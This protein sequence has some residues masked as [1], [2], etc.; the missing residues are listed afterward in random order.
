MKHLRTLLCLLA[1]VALFATACGDDDSSDTADGGDTG[2]DSGDTDT[3]DS[4]DDGDTGDDAGDAVAGECTADAVGGELTFGTYTPTSGLDPVQI[5]GAGTTSAIENL[6]I[7]DTLIRYDQASNEFVPHMAEALESNDDASEWTLTLRE[8]VTF[9][10][11][12]PL[13]AEAVKASIERHI[14]EDSTSR[15]RGL[16][17]G[18]VASMEVVDATTL[19]FTLTEPW[20]RFP[21]LLSRPAGMITNEAVVAEVGPE[22]FQ[23]DPA[24]G[25][26]GPYTVTRFAP[27]EELVL[28][29]RDDYWGG[30]VCIETL[31][32]IWVPGGQ[33][34]WEAFQAGEIQ[35]GFL[36]EPA[37]NADAIEAGVDV[38]R[39][40]KNA[41]GVL[42][43]NNGVRGAET[44]TADV[45]VRRALQMAIDPV[46]FDERVND[47][48]SLPTSAVAH[49]TS[50][51]STGAESNRYDPDAAAALVDEVKAEGEWDGS[52]RLYCH[53]APSR[54]D[55]PIAMEA[56]LEAVGFDV[57]VK[58]DWDINAMIK[59]VLVDGDFDLAC[60]GFNIEEEIPFNGMQQNFISDNPSNF[61]G[62]ADP[63]MDQA[64]AD[65]K[66]AA[67]PEEELA[68]MADIEEIWAETVPSPIYE[69]LEEMIIA[70]GS[71]QGLLSNSASTVLFSDAFLAG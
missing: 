27:N 26:A 56:Q 23:L 31:R 47:G 5:S 71:V 63:A 21:Y 53:N 57:E 41:G 29:A 24:G 13:D 10:N 51:L 20:P 3:D 32:F 30:P 69:S 42:A 44:P 19:T 4:T 25:G 67:T 58:N 55:W 40:L 54:A 22:A 43:A 1:V 33:G 48:M 61:T 14:A 49:E 2:S 37:A 52:I 15:I 34:T 11:G 50:R 18:N 39:Y 70:D 66:A 38:L 36:R 60:W 62:Y 9:S 7:F 16:I 59:A 65:L 46:L 68:A 8:G 45:R 35:A 12:D 28:E 6:A 17:A 64:I